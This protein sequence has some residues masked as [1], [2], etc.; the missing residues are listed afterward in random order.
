MAFY[1]LPLIAQ[2]ATNEIAE[3]E[4]K[5][6]M[7]IHKAD[8]SA[9]GNYNITYTRLELQIDPAVK[10]I[11]GKVTMCFI[12]Q[13]NI[14]Q[15]EMDLSDS[16]RLDSIIYHGSIISA[17]HSGDLIFVNFNGLLPGGLQ[18]S[19]QIYYQGIPAGGNGFGSFVQNLHDSVPVIWT[20]SEPYGA[21]D[22]WPCKQDLADKIDSLDVLVTTPADYRVASNGLLVEEI[23][24][25]VNKI[26]H[27]KH[28]YPIATYLVCFAVTNYAVYSNYV[29]HGQDTLTVLNYVYPEHLTDAQNQTPKIVA[30]VQLYDSL[31]GVYPFSN[32]KYGMAEF[33]WG[34]G[35]EHQ[36]M[37]FVTNFGFELMAHELGHHWFGDKVTC[38]SW[39]DIWLNEGFATYLS[40]LCYENIEPVYYHA[41]KNGSRTLATTD[42]TGTVWCDDT[43]SVGRI[44]SGRLTYAKGAM[45]LH[46][47]RFELG[48]SLFFTG[49]RNYLHNTLLAYNFATTTNFKMQMEAVSGRDLTLF[50]NQWIYG[51]GYPTFTVNWQQDFANRL[52]IKL[53]Q[54]TSDPSSISLFEMPVPLKIFGGANDTT[55]IFYNTFY[56]QRFDVDLPFIADSIQFDPDIWLIS[57]NNKVVRTGA[58]SFDF[59]IYPNPVVGEILQIR[60]ESDVERRVQFQLVNAQGQIVKKQD[61]ELP[62][63][64]T[65]ISRDIRDLAIGS[66]SASFSLSGKVVAKSFI[67]PAR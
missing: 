46:M 6:I 45:V 53:D 24:L 42:L 41:S 52:S 37:T 38:A 4:Q 59:N 43:T 57:K 58:Y 21:K 16:L 1:G 14:A 30:M 44:F 39:H 56:G 5:S 11:N 48:D 20:L 15:L 34:G 19:L 2:H 49:L 25:G 13:G 64:A 62:Q 35:M 51:S 36:T 23:P 33:G 7:H 8:R 47:L 60:V 18:D 40:M 54:S 27:W 10:Y 67:K 32:E 63:G 3:A 55:V 26:Y 29:P 12:P 9:F 28:R 66:Y 50:F 31:F 17:V 22:W 61:I 65:L